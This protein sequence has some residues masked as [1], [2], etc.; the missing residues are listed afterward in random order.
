MIWKTL[1]IA[2]KRFRKL[3]APHLMKEDYQGVRYGDGIRTSKRK[4]RKGAA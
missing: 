4:R 3:N 2:E 1:M